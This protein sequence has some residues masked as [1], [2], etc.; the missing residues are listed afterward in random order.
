ME[1]LGGSV[2]VVAE[3]TLGQNFIV[4]GVTSCKRFLVV[5]REAR[6]R[7]SRPLEISRGFPSMT[8]L[9]FCL[10][11]M[12]SVNFPTWRNRCV[13][14]GCDNELSFLED[15]AVLPNQLVLSGWDSNRNSLPRGLYFGP[16]DGFAIQQNLTS[17][18]DDLNRFSFKNGSVGWTQNTG[19]FR[20]LSIREAEC[21]SQNN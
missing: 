13:P 21:L 20:L 8:I 9:T 15:V 4:V 14:R 18:S 17:A 7:N 5:A 12:R 10:R 2:G 1:L 6:L 19:L 16:F 11:R 3:D